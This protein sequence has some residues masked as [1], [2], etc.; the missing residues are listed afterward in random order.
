M[1]ERFRPGDIFSGYYFPGVLCGRA[2]SFKK[3]IYQLL[4]KYWDEISKTQYLYEANKCGTFGI[5]SRLFKENRFS[6]IHFNT[7]LEQH[8]ECFEILIGVTIAVFK[9][10]CPF[11]IRKNILEKNLVLLDELEQGLSGYN[12][13]NKNLIEIHHRV[14]VLY[15]LYLLYNSQYFI[16]LEDSFKQPPSTLYINPLRIPISLKTFYGI[17]ETFR[18]CSK[19]E[20]F[21]EAKAII[22][23]LINHDIINICL[24]DGPQYYYKD[25]YG[26]PLTPDLLETRFLNNE[27]NIEFEDKVDQQ[28]DL[29][30]SKVFKK[31]NVL[32]EKLIHEA[33]LN[34]E[35]QSSIKRILSDL[36]IHYRQCIEYRDEYYRICEVIKNIPKSEIFS[37]SVPRKKIRNSSNSRKVDFEY[38]R[39]EATDN[40]ESNDNLDNSEFDFYKSWQ[41]L[42]CLSTIRD[43]EEDLIA[44]KG[45]EV[46]TEEVNTAKSISNI[47]ET[48]EEGLNL[49][50]EDSEVINPLDLDYI[51]NSN[52][53]KN[54]LNSATVTGDKEVD[55]ILQRIDILTS[56][57]RTIS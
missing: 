47:S 49:G 9:I 35:L 57:N 24:Y 12:C 25:R 39:V 32:H 55:Y 29:D 51:F 33:S 17:Y 48:T 27:D 5:L 23:R 19:Y 43:N 34:Y 45:L 8:N 6:S 22:W 26:N 50:K 52:Q 53:E 36:D 14:S 28:L 54:K 10:Q 37:N 31:V 42:R 15:L 41:D 1:S 38:G 30:S 11:E 46:M 21:P 16:P 18:D 2:V 20:V 7:E 56:I 40:N 44:D 13:D 3:D 4:Q